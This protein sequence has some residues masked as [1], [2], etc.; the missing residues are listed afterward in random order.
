MAE[1]VKPPLEK[2]QAASAPADTSQTGQAGEAGKGTSAEE[3]W[4]EA[5]GK[6]HFKNPQ[7]MW[8]S[9]QELEKKLDEQATRIK[10][11][12][13]FENQIAPVLNAVWTDPELLTTVRSK[14]GG[15]QVP[16]TSSP[17]TQ[18]KAEEKPE[19]S[20]QFIADILAVE[21]ERIV[22]DFEKEHGLDGLSPEELKKERA[23]IGQVLGRWTEP[24]KRI[25]LSRLPTLLKD[26]YVIAHKGE[27]AEKA[28]AEA[29]AEGKSAQ[30]ASIGTV[31]SKGGEAEPTVE[32]TPKEREVAEKAGKYLSGFTLDKYR[33][34]LKKIRKK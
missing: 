33:K 29:L 8:V 12:E 20:G 21:E 17:S 5:Q 2:G 9:Y 30:A 27:L 34:G 18:K 3:W 1:D 11:A 10:S 13:D 32:L 4:G 23:L 15:T 6:K 19:V 22:R 25:P 14:L 16:I 28:K 7:D 24:S 26:A 31:P